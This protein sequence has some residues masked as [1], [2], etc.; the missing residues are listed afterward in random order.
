S[1]TIQAFDGEEYSG[2]VSLEYNVTIL[3]TAP[4]VAD[5]IITTNP[6]TT[7]DLVAGYDASDADSVD[8]PLTIIIKWY[9]NGQ[10]QGLPLAN[11][12]TISS[13]N[14][15]KSQVWWFTV[16]AFDGEV[17]STIK[18]SAHR[19]ILNT[20]PVVSNLS[21]PSSPT[22]TDDLKATWDAFDAD[23][24]GLSYTIKWYTNS[25]GTWQQQVSYNGYDALP[26]IATTKG[27]YWKV[28]IQ[29]DDGDSDPSTRYSNELN[30][31][32]V[33]ILNTPPE[34]YNLD[35]TSNPT[36]ITDLVATWVNTDNDS[37]SLTFTI[38]WYLNGI[39]NSSWLTDSSGATLTAGNTT[40]TDQWS[41]TIQAFDGEEYSSIISLGYN[42]TI[43]N[44]APIIGNLTLT[45]NPRTVDDLVA[46]YDSSDVD[47]IDSPLTII[48]KW[49]KNGQEQGSPLA[50]VTIINSG[51]TSKSQIWWFTVQA[52]DGEAYSTIK[53]S[54]HREILNTAPVV[55]NLGLPSNPTTMDDLETTWDAFDADNDGLSYT[56]KWYTNSSGTWQQQVSYNGYN[57]LPA[58]ATAKGQYWKV[59]IQLDDGDSD[60]STRYSNELNSSSVLIL[61]TPPEV[62]NLDLTS[63]PTTNDDLTATWES[64]DNDSDSLTFY[65]VWYLNGILN[66]TLQTSSMSSTLTSINTS[67]GQEWS[68]NV[69]ANDG[70]INSTE[71]T[72]GYNITI[73]N[74]IPTVTNPTFN[75]TS[76]VADDKG[77]NIT[78]T[79][80]DADGD[81]EVI[82]GKLIVYWY[83]NWVYNSVYDNNTEIDGDNTTS[84]QVWSYTIR[85]FDGE[86]YSF[87]VSSIQGMT[88]GSRSNDPPYAENLTITP[89]TPKTHQSLI[90]S[91][92]YA[93]NDSDPQYGYEVRW[94][95]NG[96]LQSAYN[97]Q[98]IIPATTTSKGQQWNFSVRVFDGITWGTYYNSSLYIIINS[99]PQVDNLDVTINPTTIDDLI[100]SWNFNDNDTDSLTF[101]VTWYLNG[102]FNSSWSTT[103]SSTTLSAGNTSK[104]DLWSFT[105]QAYDGAEYSSVVSLGYNVTILNT[106]PV[107]NSLTITST[108]TTIDNLVATF[109]YSDDDTT[110]NDSL[111]FIIKWYK[112]G[113]E[114]GLP[115][116]NVTTISSGYT[117]KSQVWWFTVQVFDG[118]A[119]SMIK[120]SAHREILNTAPVVSNLGLPSSPTTTD[121]LE[122][123]WDAF[124]ADNDGLGYTIRWYTNISGTWQ[125]QTAYNG[126]DTLPA[127]VTAKGQYW[128]F[129]IMLNDGDSDPST[130]Y[131]NE[132]NSTPVLIL[133]TPPTVYNLDL[134]SNPKTVNELVA[135]WADTDIDSD[136]LTFTISWYLNG[137][138]NSSWSTSSSSTTLSAGNTSKNDL[139]SFTIQAY[140][141]EEYSSVVSLGYNVTILNTVPMVDDLT[142]TSTPTTIDNLVATFDYSDDDTTDNDSLIFI[143]KWYKNG[144]E[145]GLPLANVTTISSGY[146]NKS[147]VWWFTVQVFD[148]EAYSMIKESAH[149]EILNTAPVVSNLGL[150]SSPTTTDDLEATW[151]AFDADNDGLGYTIKWFTNSSGT[152]QHQT[153]YNG[154]DTLPASVTAKGQY[155]KFFVQLDDGDSDPSTRYSN[156]LNSTPVLILNTPPIV[157]NL[158]L[159]TNPTTSSNL[160]ATWESSDDDT[161]ESLTFTITWYLNG[162]FNSSWSTTTMS[163]ILG[164]SNT[165][166]TDQWYFT[167]KASDGEM[168]SSIISLASNVTILNTIPIIGNLTITMNPTTT[169]DLVVGWDYE[170]L[171]G[172]PRN[173]GTAS[174]IWY[175]NGESVGG[176]VNTSSVLSGNTTKNQVWWYTVQCYDGQAYSLLRESPHV[177]IQNSAPINISS[178]PLP[179]SPIVETGLVLSESILLSSLM[180]ADGDD[181]QFVETIRWYKDST[182]QS[183]LNGSLTVPGNRLK[184]GETWHYTVV[185]SDS[186]AT[187]SMYTSGDILILNSIPTITLAYFPQANV[188]T[189][190]NL[191]VSYLYVDADGESVS[192]SGIRWY[193]STDTFNYF[194]VPSYNGN[195]TLPSSATNKGER[196]KFEIKITD[197]YNESIDWIISDYL[198]IQNSEP[199][200]DPFTISITGGISTSDSLSLTYSW[201]DDDDEDSET[202]TTITWANSELEL[203][204]NNLLSLSSTYT[205]AGQRWWV[206]ITPSDGEEEGSSIIS[207]YYGKQ[208]TIGNTPPVITETSIQGVFN[209]TT[210]Y[211]SS[212]G[213][214]FDLVINYTVSDIDQDEGA[215]GYGIILVDNY[216][217]EAEYIWFRNRSGVVT[218][219]QE[220]M[221]KTSVPFYSTKKGDVWWIQIRPRDLFGDYGLPVNSSYITI[222]NTAPQI[223]NLQWSQGDYR[224][225]DNLSFQYDFLDF[226]V[227]D[228]EVNITIHWYLNG[229]YNPLY[230]NQR[231]ITF[232]EIVKGETWRAECMV[233]DGEAYSIWFS[234]PTITIQNTAPIASFV[235][236][237]PSS[238][239]TAEYL[240]AAWNYSDVDGD[241]EQQARIFWYK[242][243]ILQPSL[244]DALMVLSGNTSKNELWYYT[245][246][247]YDGEHYSILVT[248][249][250]ITIVNTAPTLENI[251][252]TN[253]NPNTTRPL[254]VEWTFLDLDGDTEST[255]V[256]IR[257]FKDGIYQSILDDFKN[258]PSGF[259]TKGEVWYYTVQVFDGQAYSI[260]YSSLLITIANAPPS[261]G[262]Y[263][264]EFDPNQSQV[265]GPDVRNTLT[266]RVFYVEGELISISYEF[267]DDDLP[268]DADQSRIYWYYYDN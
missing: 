199:W 125:Q 203:V 195:L 120:E 138:F 253:T 79:F 256:I 185:P 104:N 24:D 245:I 93:D 189:I 123:T 68:F 71:I 193:R 211:G 18:E 121:D 162:L 30:S 191:T 61:N 205:R 175:L 258:V 17:Y 16:Q 158:D 131:S 97:N 37:D 5:L 114:Q 95:M 168:E 144:Q 55:S 105:I 177:Q 35:L 230:D 70:E 91:F 263:S 72:L 192:I 135:I 136:S 115:L 139:W 52:F 251:S 165:T 89:S 2:I 212:F 133:N 58:S 60:P 216:L 118:E 229:T 149:R 117:N 250:F 145:Q 134:T 127:S 40:K 67:K 181:I 238:P 80:I 77:F 27:Q 76:P 14:T 11:I 243:N 266:E 255:T 208:I 57:T 241:L 226:D 103:S 49:Y 81:S 169:D 90:A 116:A 88:I 227:A 10:E 210:W 126:Y 236:L 224:T 124:D 235:R 53:E 215:P 137:V 50:N 198:E 15:S 100:A 220:L 249:P 23:N 159:T 87:E 174:I 213:T 41:F 154:Y 242:N 228:I 7:D 3:N 152:W 56:I 74:S 130:R 167:V 214:N 194:L 65:V 178:L 184:K 51:N 196:W 171:D 54:V 128:K 176:L 75:V 166:K 262:D 221:G 223:L 108:P 150:P 155:W 232:A 247:V 204:P 156:E 119:Y 142:I 29:L 9:K 38:S 26:A 46:S 160:V 222:G 110:D 98:L 268:L 63:N 82:T 111:I 6:T 225:T 161:G 188:K 202:G 197:G 101:T 33:L 69:T 32:S 99:P 237:Q 107:V 244:N 218:R 231:V 109:D 4:V 8:S 21:L 59:Y 64:N 94:Y 153:A 172:D 252:F 163:A 147:Q 209:A 264:Y 112:N 190:H 34:V 254:E 182:L 62:Y 122:A 20:A 12:T 267:V 102:V 96:S 25:S 13:G 28:Y 85:V 47:S 83:V 234:L 201:Y 45:T 42:V 246:E 180:D 233:F 200:V 22:T 217:S 31:S 173:D 132:L 36:T 261:I 19:E 78:Y 106:A 39:F 170:D 43:L 84:G 92:D 113:Q 146:T 86:A 129:Y 73:Q 164:A 148:G 219:I 48:I 259:T 151:D 239:T 183:D 240:L 44:T 207:W 143:I 186:L 66:T 260:E 141:G 1:F 187:G 157:H 248:S 179:S 257:W 206:T 140:D 265:E